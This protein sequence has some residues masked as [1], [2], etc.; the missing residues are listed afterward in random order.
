M[1]TRKN[2]MFSKIGECLFLSFLFLTLSCAGLCQK[3]TSA[4][5][6]DPW[7]A[8]STRYYTELQKHA[9][10]KGE[11]VD[12]QKVVFKDGGSVIIRHYPSD[13]CTEIIKT[14]HSEPAQTVWLFDNPPPTKPGRGLTKDKQ[15]LRPHSM[16]LP[17]QTHTAHLDYALL[18]LSPFNKRQSRSVAMQNL[19]QGPGPGLCEFPHAGIFVQT[20]N[21]PDYTGWYTIVTRWTDGC[22]AWQGHNYYT[23]AWGPVNWT[24]CYH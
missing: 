15:N 20:H 22:S 21:Y 23:G 14:E 9:L 7:T 17:P 11:K 1:N 10:S 4:P 13:H 6:Q 8:A 18:N 12:E 24:A 2:K 19:F 3:T 16:S 5:S